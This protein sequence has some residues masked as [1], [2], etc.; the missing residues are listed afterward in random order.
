MRWTLNHQYKQYFATRPFSA[1]TYIHENR[2]K[3][4]PDGDLANFIARRCLTYLSFKEFE[5]GP[6]SGPHEGEDFKERTEQYS[7]LDYSSSYWKVH[8]SRSK[9]PTSLTEQALAFLQI[10]TL[11]QTAVQVLWYSDNPAVAGW[12]AKSNIDPLH[13]A[14]YCGL[15]DGATRLLRNGSQ[16]DC[17]DSAGTTPL[18][19]AIMVSHPSMVRALLRQG[20]NPNLTC[21]RGSSALNRAI[22]VNHVIIVRIL[23]DEPDID[24]QTPDAS[25]DDKNR[26]SEILQTLLQK[27]DINVNAHSGSYKHTALTLAAATG[28]AQ[29]VRQLLSHQKIDVN[30]RNKW[31]TALTEAATSGYFAVVEALLDHNADP[32]IQEGPSCASGTPLNRAIDNGY[33]STVHLLL[34]RGA[35]A[36]VLDTYNRTIVHSAAVNGRTEILKIL[37]EADCGVDINAQ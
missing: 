10:E 22:A 27:P 34:Q 1:Q 4:F 7:L 37:F 21:N 3:W 26:C 14:A 18:M 29:I 5:N 36:K 19:Y 35:N 6:C 9:E 16:I 24:L 30:R 13:L 2:G 28:D 23:L 33:T 12:D 8:A 32:E 17:R 25:R 15:A 31:C 11:L 20:A